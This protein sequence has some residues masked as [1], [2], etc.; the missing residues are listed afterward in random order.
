LGESDDPLDGLTDAEKTYVNGL[1]AAYAN[2]S[3]AV[4]SLENTIG[5][6]AFGALLGAEA[7]PTEL[8]S[9][10]IETE[11]ELE[12]LASTFEAAPPPSMAELADENQ[13]VA[14]A[15]RGSFDP[16]VAATVDE[17]IQHALEAGRNFLGGLFGTASAEG[18]SQ[19]T[20]SKARIIACITDEIG[21]IRAS[22]TAGEAALDAAVADV[23][24][25]Q[26]MGE[27]FLEAFLSG[28]CFIATAA[29]GTKSAIEIDILRDFRDRVLMFSATGRDLVAFYYVASPPVA[30]FV[31]QHEVVRWCV[32]EGVVDPVVRVVGVL[33]P[34]WN[35]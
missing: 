12:A 17:G 22:L 34:L 24:L 13:A 20:S 6:E 14:A 1:K 33:E 7:S 25:A 19:G 26:Q 31:A 29:Y 9:S 11:S 32:R 35:Y 3:R 18:E 5:A 21:R 10:V 8:V 28:E 16:C 30:T 23:Q 27:D 4:S 15:L 2:A